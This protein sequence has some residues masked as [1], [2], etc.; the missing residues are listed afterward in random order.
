ME[1]LRLRLFISIL[2]FGPR[3]ICADTNPTEA[4]V[5][6]DMYNSLTSRDKLSNWNSG[7]PCAVPWIG[8]TCSGQ[9]VTELKLSG[10]GLSGPMSYQLSNLK[11]LTI[12]DLST[13]NLANQIPYGLPPN[14]TRI[15][16]AGNNFNGGL[17]YSISSMKSLE[18][19]NVSHNNLQG[20]LGDMF[21]SLSSL[22]TLDVSYNILSGSLPQSFGLLASMTTMDLENNQFTGNINL[23][24]NLSLE[25]L[26]VAN[27]QFTGYVPEQL[28]SINLKKDGN[29][30]SSGAAPPPP[31]GTPPLSP[32]KRNHKSSGNSNQSN[33]NGSNQ[34]GLGGGTIAAIVI[35]ILVVGAIVAFF[36][37]RRRRTRS[38]SSDIEKLNNQHLSYLDSNELQG[39]KYDNQP[40][41]NAASNGVEETKSVHAPST[42]SAKT[43]ETPTPISLRPPPI[44]RHKSFDEESFS[45]KPIAKK[46]NAEEIDAKLYSVAELQMATGSFSAECLIGEG[47]LGRA[48][49]AQFDD[50]KVFAVKRVDPSALPNHLEDFTEIVA[51]ISHLRHPNIT[52]LVGYCSQHGQHLLVYEFHSNGSLHDLM[53][54]S[55]EDS[56]PLEWNSRVTIALGTARALE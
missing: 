51:S 13:N 15:N 42:I 14:A 56:K 18:Y 5:L 49:R 37:I 55:D 2:I 32:R 21:S 16:L 39:K 10:L 1:R 54:L 28:K 31:P 11:S 34:S 45:K 6:R 36:L 40:L 46:V 19:L 23:L 35:S 52:E 20:Q 29:S 3:F 22:S 9:S 12:L 44:E 41:A 17:P 8:V 53:H 38:T 47:S 25:N 33:S 30:W 43:F 26:N 50:G 7:D 24:G 4:S 48:Y 27:N